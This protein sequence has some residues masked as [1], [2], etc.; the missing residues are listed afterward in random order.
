MIEVAQ[1][2]DTAVQLARLPS[3]LPHAQ[4]D[5]DPDPPT[6]KAS[7]HCYWPSPRRQRTAPRSQQPCRLRC[8][9]K[10]V[11]PVHLYRRP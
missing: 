10:C 4:P 9:T 6:L 3:L 7:E 11:V 8:S 1:E 5:T 2:Q